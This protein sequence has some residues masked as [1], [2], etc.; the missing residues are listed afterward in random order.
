MDAELTTAR[1]HLR[2]PA[3]E[4][5]QEISDAWCRDPEVTRY[6]IWQPHKDIAEA[7]AFLANAI[8]EQEA[9]KGAHWMLVLKDDGR[10]IGDVGARLFQHRV[11]IGYVLARPFWSRGYMSEAVSAIA[12][13]LLADPGIFRVWATCE[14]AN[15]ASARVM[16][17]A[18]MELEGRLHRWLVMPALGT[19]P[20]DVL[21]Y[22][23]CR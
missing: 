9:G 1:L 17:K 4:D 20:R 11:E 15:R 2:P 22:A 19:E 14:P 5:A 21:C 8:A 23:R 16:E 6:M 12:K 13:N 7:R 3:I 10:I 18:G